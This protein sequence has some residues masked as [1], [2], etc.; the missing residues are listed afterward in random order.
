MVVEKPT[1]HG[2]QSVLFAD[3]VRT[4]AKGFLAAD[5]QHLVIHQVTEELPA[6]YTSNEILTKTIITESYQ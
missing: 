4:S 1:D 6:W 2:P 3:M 5:G